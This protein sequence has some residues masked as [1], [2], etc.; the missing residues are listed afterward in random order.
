MKR[1]IRVVLRFY[2]HREITG[3]NRIPKTGPFLLVG[4]HVSILD[5]FYIGSVIP[6]DIRY[7]AKEE[8]FSHPLLR[9][10]LRGVG[11]FPV[12]REKPSIRSIKIALGHLDKGK[13]IGIFPG[14]TR[15]EKMA[16]EEVKQ[17]AAYLSLKTGAPVLPVYIDGTAEALPPGTRWPRP[18]RVRIRI[19]ELITPEGKGKERQKQLSMKILDT[20]SKLSHSGSCGERIG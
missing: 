15:R 10:F 17:G 2:H 16:M 8:S 12:N 9:R 3:L 14:G 11:A 7:M 19:G 4:N 13:V 5:P 20:L 18:S 1:L 6:R